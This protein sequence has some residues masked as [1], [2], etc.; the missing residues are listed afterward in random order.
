MRCYID[1]YIKRIVPQPYD[2][3]RCEQLG[4]PVAANIAAIHSGAFEHEWQL[5][6]IKRYFCLS[7]KIPCG[8]SHH[9]W[10]LV[11]PQRELSQLTPVI[12][13]EHFNNSPI[14]TIAFI[15]KFEKQFLYL[16]IRG[17]VVIVWKIESVFFHCISLF[18]KRYANA[19]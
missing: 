9:C 2:T 14:N 4:K 18:E 7:S 15:T 10:Q 16:F 17:S 19:P 1:V 12:L 11:L 8:D 6:H 5:C 13:I 3:I